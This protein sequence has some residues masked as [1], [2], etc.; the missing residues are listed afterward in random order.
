MRISAPKVAKLEMGST[1]VHKTPPG[2]SAVL[3]CCLPAC[4]PSTAAVPQSPPLRLSGS[5]GEMA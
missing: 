3:A 2:E 5:R 1:G 4:L